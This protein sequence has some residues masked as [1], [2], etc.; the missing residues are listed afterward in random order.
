MSGSLFAV[1]ERDLFR[2]RSPP[3]GSASFPLEGV[4]DRL[5]REF[6][7][8]VESG[9]RDWLFDAFAS[10]RTP[11]D[12]IC[13]FEALCPYRGRGRDRGGCLHD[14]FRS[15]NCGGCRRERTK[16]MER[17]VEQVWAGESPTDVDSELLGRTVRACRNS[18]MSRKETVAAAKKH[19]SLQAGVRPPAR[20]VCV[21]DTETFCSPL[22]TYATCF[23]VG[24]VVLDADEL[25]RALG[26]ARKRWKAAG[27]P[28]GGYR[29]T[30]E[31]C[32][33]LFEG[34]GLGRRAQARERGV[35][36]YTGKGCV[37]NF[38]KD[39]WGTPA[40]ECWGFNSARFDHD[41]LL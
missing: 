9:K 33:R 22:H 6:V 16:R 21:Y 34:G 7:D 25:H 30:D 18:G 5:L 38:L 12:G 19:R 2:L 28:A 24:A 8:L 1:A 13:R 35:A 11:W 36:L 20:F 4:H 31:E 3:R 29:L 41:V 26:E 14:R 40:V 32:H 27:R 10:Y 23:A 39:L 37:D 15:D 17:V